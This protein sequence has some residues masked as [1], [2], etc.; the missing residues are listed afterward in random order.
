MHRYTRR[1]YK[2]NINLFSNHRKW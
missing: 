2:T 1:C